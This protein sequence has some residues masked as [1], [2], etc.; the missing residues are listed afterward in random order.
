MHPASP[1][2]ILQSAKSRLQDLS[3]KFRDVSP[4]LSIERGALYFMW[5]FRRVI[6]SSRDAWVQYDSL[7][8][9]LSEYYVNGPKKNGCD[10]TTQ[11]I[12]SSRSLFIFP[13][14]NSI[15]SS[16]CCEYSN[17]VPLYW[18]FFLARPMAEW[19][20]C[21]IHLRRRQCRSVVLWPIFCFYR[22]LCGLSIRLSFVYLVWLFFVPECNRTSSLFRAWKGTTR[23]LF[24]YIFHSDILLIFRPLFGLLG[25]K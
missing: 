25:A 8:S 3:S 14:S 5:I 23:A 1:G 21:T 16:Q 11:N 10:Q 15:P 7:G 19:H 18:A 6:Q 9:S 2:G 20:R 12:V 17:R 4:V 22:K 13:I 24:L